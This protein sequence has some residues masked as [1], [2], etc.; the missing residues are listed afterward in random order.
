[1]V[2]L[3]SIVIVI[4]VVLLIVFFLGDVS[5]AFFSALVR[6]VLPRFP[7]PLPAYLRNAYPSMPRQAGVETVG[8]GNSGRLVV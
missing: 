8:S 7:K 3:I 4:V 5:T 1:M 6:G 2:L